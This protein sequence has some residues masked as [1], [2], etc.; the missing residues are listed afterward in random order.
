[1]FVDLLIGISA[2]NNG[3]WGTRWD[4]GLW[5]CGSEISGATVGIVGLGRIGLAVAKRLQA[6][7]PQRILY[8]GHS[9]KPCAKEVRIFN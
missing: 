4:N 9:E 2:V 1:M 8:C 7:E 6:F 5:M 3:V